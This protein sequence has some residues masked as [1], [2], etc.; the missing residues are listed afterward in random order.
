M[1]SCPQTVLS[2]PS[3]LAK[4]SPMNKDHSLKLV[5]GVGTVAAGIAVL[6]IIVAFVIALVAVF[7]PA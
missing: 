7:S 2:D 6:A 3:Y 1:K 4:L 5:L